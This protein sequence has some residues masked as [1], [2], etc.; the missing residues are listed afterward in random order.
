[1]QCFDLYYYFILFFNENWK[2]QKKMTKVSGK[3]PK[4]FKQGLKSN[5]QNFIQFTKS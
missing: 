5:N 2:Y 1:M 4:K 3:K